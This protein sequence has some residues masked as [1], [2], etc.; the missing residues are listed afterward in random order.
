MVRDLAQHI[1]GNNEHP[2]PA[3]RIEGHDHPL[4]SFHRAGDGAGFSDRPARDCGKPHGTGNQRDLC[5]TGS[6][7]PTS[8]LDPVGVLRP[9]P[10]C[11]GEHKHLS[12]ER[13]GPRY[14]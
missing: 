10:G 2:V 6:G 14:L 7:S 9:S 1:A 12:C 11:R 8:G 4:L 5:R 13:A 3:R